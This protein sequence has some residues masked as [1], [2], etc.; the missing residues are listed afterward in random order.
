MWNSNT[1]IKGLVGRLIDQLT[2]WFI[3]SPLPFSS[4]LFFCVFLLFKVCVNVYVCVCTC[5]GW[6]EVNLGCHPL[7]GVCYPVWL[8]NWDLGLL[9]GSADWTVNPGMLLAPLSHQWYFKCVLLDPALLS[10]FWGQHISKPP[11]V[12]M[13]LQGFL[14]FLRITNQCIIQKTISVGLPKWFW[15]AAL[16]SWSPFLF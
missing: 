9:I 13:Q 14:L 5:M 8:Y 16:V 11:D 6:P 3:H 1:S 10:E 15:V 12:L 4:P 7:C 2:H